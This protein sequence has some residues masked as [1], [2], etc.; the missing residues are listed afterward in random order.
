MA[1]TMATTIDEVIETVRSAATDGPAAV[2]AAAV[3]YG[4]ALVLA[5]LRCRALLKQAADSE[6]DRDA[7]KARAVDAVAAL[8]AERDAAAARAGRAESDAA[9]V[10]ISR[11]T[12]R[13]LNTMRDELTAARAEADRLRALPTYE[14]RTTPP[15]DAE[16]RAHAS[17]GCAWLVSWRTTTGRDVCEVRGWMDALPACDATY[18]ALRGGIPCAWPVVATEGGA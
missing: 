1:T 6:C 3:G 4:A 10:E 17:A 13:Q 8:R 11:S 2:E 5:G 12:T 7:A 15:T 16:K 14:A 18:V 9:H